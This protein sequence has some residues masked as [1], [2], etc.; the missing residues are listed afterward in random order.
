MALQSFSRGGN[1]KAPKRLH[2]HYSAWPLAN[3]RASATAL[4]SLRGIRAATGSRGPQHAPILLGW[5]QRAVLK[6]I[7]AAS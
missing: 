4:K 7:S 3:A 2:N 6:L 5:R 1:R